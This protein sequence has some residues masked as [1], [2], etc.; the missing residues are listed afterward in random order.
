MSSN[1]GEPIKSPEITAKLR[2]ALNKRKE[3]TEIVEGAEGSDFRIRITGKPD[4]IFLSI[5]TQ[6]NKMPEIGYYELFTFIGSNSV[7]TAKGVGVYSGKSV[8]EA[9]DSFLKSTLKK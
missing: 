2:I 8:E 6:V 5:Q 1:H 7:L 9:L 3:I 4:P